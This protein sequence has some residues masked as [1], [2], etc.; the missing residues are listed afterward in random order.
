MCLMMPATTPS[1]TTMETGEPRPTGTTSEP[2][3]EP[4]AS[5]SNTSSVVPDDGDSA[6]DEVKVYGQEEDDER[7]TKV[8]EGGPSRNRTIVDD[9]EK[10]TLL[11]EADKEPRRP[12]LGFPSKYSVLY[13]F[14]SIHVL[15]KCLVWK[16]KPLYKAF[17]ET[18]SL[19]SFTCNYHIKLGN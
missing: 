16:S 13:N 11:T 19:F 18:V 9:D 4:T 15:E 10:A 2:V 3:K 6:T 1:M 8:F 7:E 5:S 14:A 17:R 12:D